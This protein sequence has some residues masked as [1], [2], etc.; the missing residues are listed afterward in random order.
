MKWKRLQR[1]RTDVREKALNA[2]RQFIDEIDAGRFPG[3]YLAITGT[4]A[5]F[6]GPQGVQRLAPLAQRMATAFTTDARFDNPRAVQIRLPGSDHAG[7]V[8]LGRRVRST[9]AG[10]SNEQGRV[11]AVVDDA[12]LDTFATAVTGQLGGRVGIDD[13]AL[14][15]GLSGAS[16][17]ASGSA[18]A[19]TADE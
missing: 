10:G 6:N 13:I 2:L 16:D 11:V 14:S 5:F 4:S 18:S 12:Y 1:V 3:L 15:D 7:L 19:D 17:P 8:E 9:Y